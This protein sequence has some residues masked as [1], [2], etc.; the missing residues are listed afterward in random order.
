MAA[1]RD[2]LRAPEHRLLF[3]GIAVFKQRLARALEFFNDLPDGAVQL[4]AGSQE[5]AAFGQMTGKQYG[6]LA[7]QGNVLLFY[8][9]GELQKLGSILNEQQR[10]ALAALCEELDGA[11][12]L[13]GQAPA[14][15]TDAKEI[16]KILGDI[17][18]RMSE[19]AGLLGDFGAPLRFIAGELRSC[20]LKPQDC[21]GRRP[22]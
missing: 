19:Q 10:A 21:G 4:S 7:F 3:S 1:E 2:S 18:E 16:A 6:D 12:R 9:R 17:Y 5:D 14:G 20:A 8:L 11:I 15:E 13:A 22:A